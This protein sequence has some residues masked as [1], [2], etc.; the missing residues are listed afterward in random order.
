MNTLLAKP[1]MYRHA[2]LKYGSNCGMYCTF[3]FLD[4]ILDYNNF[5]IMY[6]IL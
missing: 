3:V 1:M 4:V 6:L 5:C 2:I